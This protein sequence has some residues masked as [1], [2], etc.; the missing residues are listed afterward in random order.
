MHL[1]LCLCRSNSPLTAGPVTGSVNFVVNS[2]IEA[3]SAAEVFAFGQPVLPRPPSSTGRRQVYVLGAYPS[4][5]HV[6]WVPPDLPGLHTRPIKAMIVDNEPVRFWDV[7]DADARF[8][9][10]RD[11]VDWKP[12]WGNVRP[13]PPT[14]NGP[15]GKWVTSTSSPRWVWIGTRSA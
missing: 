11:A 2:S 3:R 4:G 9:V 15:S 8:E 12:E 7:Y 6:G 5:L 1:G 13:A 14:S 10:W